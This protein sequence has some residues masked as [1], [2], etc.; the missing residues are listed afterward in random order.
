MAKIAAMNKSA[1]PKGAI[2]SK[3]VIQT[4]GKRASSIGWNSSASKTN[5][6]IAALY[7]QHVKCSFQPGCRVLDWHGGKKLVQD[8]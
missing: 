7:N 4:T 6:I 5:C 1:V 8:K 2:R 3:S